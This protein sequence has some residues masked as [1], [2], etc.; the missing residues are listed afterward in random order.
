MSGPS[1]SGL[2]PLSTTG[3]SES[4]SAIP[5]YARPVKGKPAIRVFSLDD[6]N[7]PSTTPTPPSVKLAPDTDAE[8]STTPPTKEVHEGPALLAPTPVR[9]RGVDPEK[10]G[11]P[12]ALEGNE[13]SANNPT[14]H[15][16][17][18]SSHVGSTHSTRRRN[19][20]PRDD[21]THDDADG[22][23]HVNF[24]VKEGSTRSGSGSAS[25]SASG[26]EEAAPKP[27]V[28][29]WKRTLDKILAHPEMAWIK[30]KMNFQDWKTVLRVSLSVSNS[31]SHAPDEQMWLGY[32]LVLIHKT[33]LFL[34]MAACKCMQFAEGVPR[35]AMILT[36]PSPRPDCLVHDPTTS[37]VCAGR[38]G[39]VQPLL[40]PC[41][42][43]GMDRYRYCHYV[44]CASPHR[45][46]QDCRRRSHVCLRDQPDH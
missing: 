28:P 32:L 9:A 44:C 21:T 20:G 16:S 26:S 38:R 10:L 42:G 27:P 35:E 34:G 2:G 40:L 15:R 3:E 13:V 1:T 37:A 36:H 33:G 25:G 11:V 14:S 43:L 39:S 8:V 46:R 24:P 23:K 4:H 22:E 45:S 19:G 5:T 12:E 30:P 7:S 41:P 17:R 18:A 29:L 31:I 6:N